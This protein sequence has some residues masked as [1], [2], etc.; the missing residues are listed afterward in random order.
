LPEEGDYRPP[1]PVADA[2]TNPVPMVKPVENLTTGPVGSAASPT[3]GTGTPGPAGTT[4]PTGTS[5]SAGLAPAAGTSPPAGSAVRTG[6]SSADQAAVDAARRA[7]PPQKG[8]ELT[9]VFNKNSW[10]QVAVDDGELRHGLFKAGQSQSYRADKKFLVRLGNAAGVRV[11][12]DGEDLGP[13]GG[14]NKAVSL[15]LPRPNP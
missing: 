1:G 3:G 7:Q 11:V 12:F 14:D 5:G 15:T 6:L 8:H 2:E 4:P 10:V 13:L 9:L